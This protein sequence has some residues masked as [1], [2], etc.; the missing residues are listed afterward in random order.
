MKYLGIPKSPS[1]AIVVVVAIVCSISTQ[2]AAQ[3][4][5]I[6]SFQLDGTD[7]TFPNR[8]L[9]ADA[10]GNLYGTT[11]DGGSQRAGA[12]FQLS[13][14]VGGGW[15]E[16]ILY[17]FQGGADGT[18]PSS[19]LIA[20]SAGNL[21]GE[22]GGGGSNFFGTV[23]KL[24]RSG[25]N[26]TKTTLYNFLDASTGFSP[27]GGLTFDAQGNLYGTTSQGGV[28]FGLGTVFQ[29][30]LDGNGNWTERVILG[31]GARRD[32]GGPVSGVT[33]DANGNLFVVTPIGYAQGVISKLTL[34]LNGRWKE[35]VLHRFGG[36]KDGAFPGGGLIIDPAGNLYGTALSGGSGGNGTVYKMT[37]RAKGWKFSVLYAFIGG[38]DGAG[39]N[40]TLT[41]DSSGNLLGTTT[42]GGGNGCDFGNGCGTVFKLFPTAKGPWQE[43]VL[44]QFQPDGKDGLNPQGALV[45]SQGKWYATTFSGGA[46]QSGAVFEI[47][48]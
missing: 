3:E 30:A 48:P 45:P 6:H 9:L 14:K 42:Q 43:T 41:L 28:P 16:Q 18:D 29:L 13:P 1:F 40:G 26:W 39:P 44:H 38:Q 15:T 22:T 35:S 27:S 2:A 4:Q 23:Y 8:D 10:A 37:P 11:I 33:A 25:S 20:D 12:V 46:F 17:S 32:G 31:F 34:Q 36:I 19:G 24:T 7:G 5:V 47:T 21:Y